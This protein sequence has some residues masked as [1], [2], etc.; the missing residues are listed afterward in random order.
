MDNLIER[1]RGL[2]P[3]LKGYSPDIVTE[4][5]EHYRAGCSAYQISRETGITEPRIRTWVRALGLQR[6]EAEVREMRRAAGRAGSA[7]R[8]DDLREAAALRAGAS[9]MAQRRPAAAPE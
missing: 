7:K 3:E 2:G 5:L 9:D 1:V 4:V 6:S 8:A